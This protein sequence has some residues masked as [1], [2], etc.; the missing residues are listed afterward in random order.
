MRHT[1]EQGSSLFIFSLK[2]LNT[3]RIVSRIDIDITAQP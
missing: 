2:D 3:L 1:R